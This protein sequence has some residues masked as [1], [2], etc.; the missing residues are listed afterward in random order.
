MV[1]IYEEEGSSTVPLSFFYS[2]GHLLGCIIFIYYLSSSRAR[3]G[4]GTWIRN[5]S[6]CFIQLGNQ[7]ENVGRFQ[8]HNTRSS[9]E[10]G[11]LLAD[12][13]LTVMRYAAS[14]GDTPWPY[15]QFG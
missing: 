15:R 3:P 9:L 4:R 12:G 2:P 1:R 13:L 6:R 5:T 8:F 11:S 14:G 7:V 10:S